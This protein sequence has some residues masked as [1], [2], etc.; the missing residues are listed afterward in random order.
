MFSTS[1]LSNVHSICRMKSVWNDRL[2]ESTFFICRLGE[3]SYNQNTVWTAL[4][5]FQSH[6]SS[7]IDYSS[8]KEW[9]FPSLVRRMSFWTDLHTHDDT[10]LHDCRHPICTKTHKSVSL[11][12]ADVVWKEFLKE[13]KH[14]RIRD[15][16]WQTFYDSDIWMHRFHSSSRNMLNDGE[17]ERTA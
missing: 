15:V 6:V 4:G 11:P 5:E 3:V 16:E 12:G 9:V 1:T 13:F 7:T 17:K 8:S 2:S 14:R 10:L